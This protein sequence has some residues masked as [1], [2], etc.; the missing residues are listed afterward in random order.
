MERIHYGEDMI[1]FDL[2]A[3]WRVIARGEP[4]FLPGVED[5][6]EETRRALR[7]PIGAERLSHIAKGKKN[8]VI[9][10]SDY[11][12]PH[13]VPKYTIPAILEELNGAGVKDDQITLVMGGGS[14]VMA[15]DQQ[16]EAYYGKE[17]LS[18]VRVVV[19]NPDDNLVFVGATRFNTPIFADN[20]VMESDLKIAVGWIY[21]HVKAGYGGGPKSIF[22]GIMGRESIAIHHSKH[23][24]NPD[25]RPGR[26]EGNPFHEDIEEAARLVG[27][28]YV[29]DVVLNA[30]KKLVRCVAGSHRE[31][32]QEGCGYCDKMFCVDVP[33]PVDVVLTSGYPADT[34]LYQSL[35]GVVVPAAPIVKDGGTIIHSTP[36]YHGIQDGTYK[37]FA[38]SEGL[39]ACDVIALFQKGVR[40]DPKV[41]GFYKPEVGLGASTVLLQMLRERSIRIIIVNK[42]LSKEKLN[43]MGF[44]S[45]PSMEAAIELAEK[46]H[47]EAE[48]VVLPAG[49][50]TMTRLTS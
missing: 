22:P 24:M 31:A 29:V 7:N 4:R 33:K 38:E 36:A 25:S 8:P 27:L 26:L 42:E 3:K 44:E 15:T 37:L 48:V 40:C 10:T 34:H 17:I 19:H 23:T 46:W 49:A 21:P 18:R 45:V 16:L 12:R 14:H 30:E 20:V 1:E 41:A 28:D 2:P 6:T 39:F 50:E 11:T 32:F 35:K 13:Q 47:P 9:I 43:R 5:E